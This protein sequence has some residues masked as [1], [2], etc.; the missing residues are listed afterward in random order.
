MSC[1]VGQN[2]AR[3]GVFQACTNTSHCVPKGDRQRHIGAARKEQREGG[4]ERGRGRQGARDTHTHKRQ[5]ASAR[6][7][8]PSCQQSQANRPPA[9]A[10]S[11]A[12][13][14]RQGIFLVLLL[15]SYSYTLHVTVPHGVVLSD[16]YGASVRGGKTHVC[17][18]LSKAKHKTSATASKWKKKRRKKKARMPR[19]G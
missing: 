11:P 4:R 5:S 6:E 16:V 17:E 15:C 12:A 7:S 8:G 14:A 9:P 2:N 3:H 18:C 10:P 13:K 19:G 1:H